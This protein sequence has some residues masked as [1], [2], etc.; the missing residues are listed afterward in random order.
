MRWSNEKVKWQ[1]LRKTKCSTLTSIL[2]I[3]KIFLTEPQTNWNNTLCK[4][5]NFLISCF[6]SGH[7]FQ[8]MWL[9]RKINFVILFWLGSLC[10]L[11]YMMYLFCYVTF[12][13]QGQRCMKCVALVAVHFSLCDA[14][15]YCA[16][17]FFIVL[18]LQYMHF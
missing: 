16:I 13:L 7:T 14:F 18:Y 12:I 2:H 3:L 10:S 6:E 11:R 15:F 8:K 4:S 5:H 17:S 1:Q 9:F